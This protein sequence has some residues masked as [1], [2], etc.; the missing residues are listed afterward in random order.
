[1]KAFLSFS[2]TRGALAAVGGGAYGTGDFTTVDIVM[3][4]V[5]CEGTEGDI[6]ECQ[7]AAVHDCDV[8]EAAS[9][10]CI[11]NDGA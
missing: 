10:Q 4:E 8:N 1:M 9:V 7:H 5:Q 3:D 2:L 11:P 6:R